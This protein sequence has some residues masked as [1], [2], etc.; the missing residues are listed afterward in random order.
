[1]AEMMVAES[2][3][4]PPPQA[5]YEVA[6]VVAG[7]LDAFHDCGFKGVGLNLVEEDELG[8]GGGQG[9][10]NGVQRAVLSH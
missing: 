7:A 10:L 6:A 4:E 2:R 5:H 9:A 1:M 3:T 8:A